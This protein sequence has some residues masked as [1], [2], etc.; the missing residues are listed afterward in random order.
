[1]R[2]S[3]IVKAKRKEKG[4]TLEALGKACGVG[5]STASKWET[6]RI[7]YPSVGKVE[8]IAKAFD[9]KPTELLQTLMEKE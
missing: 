7:Q 8:Q 1:M 3:E 4:M 5:K 6:G 2:F 9:M